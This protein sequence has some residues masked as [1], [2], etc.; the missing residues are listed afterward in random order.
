M[1]NADLADRHLFLTGGT[2]FVGRTL[3]DLFASH[4]RL[5]VQNFTV[6]VLSRDPEA[7]RARYP[8]YAGASW[9]RLVRGSLASLDAIPG[10]Y[11]DVVHAAADTHLQG[12]GAAWIDQIVNGTRGVLDFAVR[13]GAR[14][15]LLVSSGAVYGPQPENLAELDE[16]YLGAPSTASVS[17]TYGQAKR[18]AEQLCTIY[19]HEFGLETLSAR[20]FALAGKHLPLDGPYALGNF[21]RDALD[22]VAIRVKG[23]GTALRSYLDGEDL[24]NWLLFLLQ[25]GVAGEAYNVGADRA[26]SMKQLAELVADI[27]APGTPVLVE[28]TLG[29]GGHRSRYIPSIAKIKALGLAPRY[30][31][32]ETIRRSVK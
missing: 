18:V 21:I 26:V 14:R 10:S 25:N 9:L 4:Y 11:T 3:L 30:S 22:G 29:S 28:N 19:H 5:M 27:V 15:F 12:Q 8:D 32:E 7:F 20:C 16:D 1:A 13:C 6:T 2:G 17:S 24:A 23:D 31:L